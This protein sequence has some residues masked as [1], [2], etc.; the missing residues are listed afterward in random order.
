M[1]LTGSTSSSPT[2][3]LLE[4]QELGPGAS[5]DLLNQKLWGEVGDLLA[6]P[7]ADSA[8]VEV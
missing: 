5:P 6:S 1:G 7:P 4:M 8:Q 2:G 3:S